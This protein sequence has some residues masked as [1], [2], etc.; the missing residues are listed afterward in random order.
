MVCGLLML[1]DERI[2]KGGLMNR[3]DQGAVIELVEEEKIIEIDETIRIY[4]DSYTG[5][6]KYEKQELN[7]LIRDLFESCNINF[8]IGSG[9]CYEKLSTLGDLE[10]LIE[11]N[12]IDNK[13]DQNNKNAVEALI[14]YD[15]FRNSIYPHKKDIESNV[16]F[17][18]SNQ[19]I[20]KLSGLLS[21][22]NDKNLLKRANIFTTNYD[23]FFELSLEK[24][25]VYY[26]DGF[27][28]RLVPVFST[29]NYNKIVKQ[30]VQNT[31]RESQIPTIN[32]YKVHGS[33]TWAE[34][35]NQ[36]TYRINPSELLE[37]IEKNASVF[38]DEKFFYNKSENPKV[39]EAIGWINT[40]GSIFND[41][42]L[43]RVEEF[44]DSY[45]KLH[46]I[47]PTKKKFEE[48]LLSNVY[49]DLL[50]MYS[51]E[52]E[53][54]NSVLFVF[55]FSFKDEHIYSITKR[56]LSNPTMMMYIFVFNDTEVSGFKDMFKDHNNVFYVYCENK[57]ID[58]SEFISMMFG[59]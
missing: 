50:R 19:F 32:L 44:T 31:E 25:N 21:S 26:N 29:Q 55:G 43:E 57:N 53:K 2:G 17:D 27:S 30:I 5:K 42:M 14:L 59:G 15:F 24:N 16:S 34:S 46:I 48:T 54:N 36:I 28:G 3:I 45:K 52:L 1:N 56:A 10:S 6:T 12:I 39:S 40:F 22:R 20:L 4:C 58:L 7:K 33:L 37:A 23:M 47:N 49:Y 38:A 51:N 13:E 8:L 11:K 9:Y 35:S 18:N 41:N